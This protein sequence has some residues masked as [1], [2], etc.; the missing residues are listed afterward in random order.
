MYLIAIRVIII[1]LC[2]VHGD[3]CFCYHSIIIYII[4]IYFSDRT[5]Y[6]RVRVYSTD[7][8]AH[9][10]PFSVS[11]TAMMHRRFTYMVQY[12]TTIRSQIELPTGGTRV[13]VQLSTYYCLMVSWCAF[14]HFDELL[15]NVKVQ[16][17]STSQHMYTDDSVVLY[18]FGM[19]RPLRACRK[20]N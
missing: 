19:P 14:K 11:Q 20:H 7:R 16:K 2:D 1:I 8:F 4:F 18:D 15:S 5:Y 3:C 10:L 6:Y 13:L 12:N 9:E 17:R